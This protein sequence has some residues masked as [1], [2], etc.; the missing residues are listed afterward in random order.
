M[1]GKRK[2][3]KRKKKGGAKPTNPALYLSLIHI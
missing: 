1:A 2:T 3:T